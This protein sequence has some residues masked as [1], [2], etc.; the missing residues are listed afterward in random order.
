MGRPD[1]SVGQHTEKGAG[2]KDHQV[3]THGI[4]LPTLLTVVQKEVEGAETEHAENGK[5]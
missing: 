2:R 1:A 3:Q 5:E 4:S